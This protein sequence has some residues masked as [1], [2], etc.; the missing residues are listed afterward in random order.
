MHVIFVEPAFPNNQREFVRALLAS[1][2]RVSAIGERPVAALG[3]EIAGA[4]ASFESVRN[5]TDPEALEAAV[6]RIQEREWVDRLEA[7]IEAHIM[8]VARVR[9]ACG[10]PGTSERTAFLCRDKPAMKE[11]LRQ[12]GVAC[13]QSTGA[14]SAEEVRDFAAEV[15]YPLILKPS[16]AAGA[17]GTYKVDND[18]ELE[19]AIEDTHVAHGAPTAVEEFVEGHEGFYDTLSLD[20]KPVHEFISHY[21]PNVLEAMRTRWISPQIVVTNRM[22]AP[23]YEEV[24]AMGQ[25]VI[26]TLGIETSPTHMEWFF[27][28]K[29]L[30][31]SEIGCRPPGVGVWDLYGAGNDLDLYSEWAKL[32]VHGATDAKA[33]RRLATGMIALRPEGDG[34]IDRYEGFQSFQQKYAA[35]IFDQYL[36][37]PGTG[38]Q[39]VEAGYMAN[40]W[41]QLMHPDFDGLRE[42]MDEAGSSIKC[43]VR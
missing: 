20:G 9:A 21:Y 5:V 15:G 34:S 42:I 10:I 26:E 30:R 36:P 13:A 7:T 3:P 27:G 14:T 6:R 17:S 35:A 1:G 32:I 28:P 31:F 40:A 38:T 23:A 12:A 33:S 39:P 25:R 37:A 18:E 43:R 4:L 11:A 8:P 16:D 24:K 19:R 41:L 2:A 29:G 22:D